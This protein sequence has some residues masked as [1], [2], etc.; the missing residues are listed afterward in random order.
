MEAVPETFDVR[1]VPE[2]QRFELAVEGQ[3]SFLQYKREGRRIVMVHTEVP[4]ALRGR[5]LSSILIQGALDAAR[6]EGLT[7]IAVCPTVREY[8]TKHPQERAGVQDRD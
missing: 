3:T 2:R 1:D 6:R 8:L 5:G 4:P 7:V